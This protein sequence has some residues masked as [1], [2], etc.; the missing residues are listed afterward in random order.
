MGREEAEGRQVL[1]VLGE[2]EEIHRTG[3]RRGEKKRTDRK[4]LWWGS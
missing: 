3:L 1:D 4:E 2:E